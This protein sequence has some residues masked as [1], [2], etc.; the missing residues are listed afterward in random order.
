MERTVLEILSFAVAAAPFVIAYRIGP[1]GWADFSSLPQSAF[2]QTSAALLAAA[3]AFKTSRKGT[4]RLAHP[5]WLNALAGC[6]LWSAVSLIW[7]HNKYEGALLLIH[8]ISSALFIIPA[9]AV[10]IGE[11][12]AAWFRG[13]LIASATA[14]ALLTVFQHVELFDPVWIPQILPPA[15]TFG[16]RNFAVQFFV[17]VLPLALGAWWSA[18][19]RPASAACAAASA[20]LGLSLIY[21]GSRA[22]A[23][24]LGCQVLVGGLLLYLNGIKKPSFSSLV[25]FKAG[26][27]VLVLLA[28]LGFSRLSGSRRQIELGHAGE[29]A[30][31]VVQALSGYTVLASDWEVEAHS[32]PVNN[33]RT[34]IVLWRNAWEMIKDRPFLGVGLGNFKVFYPLYL[35]SGLE[36]KMFDEHNQPNHAHNEL[37]EFAVETGLIGLGLAV[38]LLITGAV[39]YL[40]AWRVAATAQARSL[41]WSFAVG[42]IGLLATSLVSFPLHKALPPNLLLLMA[43]AA[44]AAVPSQKK[45]LSLRGRRLRVGAAVLIFTAGIFSCWQYRRLAAEWAHSQ[46]LYAARWQRH[47]EVI[48]FSQEANRLDPFRVRLNYPAGKA[49]AMLA[50]LPESVAAYESVAR[51]Y[52]HHVNTRL[53]LG[54]SY[55]QM[56]RWDDALENIGAALRITPR[57][58]KAYGNLGYFYVRRN[59]LQ[60]AVAA[61]RKAAM[62]DADNPLYRYRLAT[63]ARRLGDEKTAEAAFADYA[64]LRSSRSTPP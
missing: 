43:A 8:W 51:A 11:K 29:R 5:I 20:A 16:H 18:K 22:G 15:A 21:A 3:V 40:R 49:Y 61:Y 60:A 33:I 14:A 56:G 2:L 19:S 64:R 58:A 48:A 17:C 4:L 32:I 47:E 57:Y 53:G 63:T 24:A 30:S 23:L 7:A 9:A 39:F 27:G 28:L 1:V 6:L 50:R 35:R 42:S 45:E 54:L 10:L 52:P 34:R 25:K 59:N 13:A 46:A 41:V 26:L 44:A 31:A 36:D 37:I 55:T 62:L 12:E 38:W